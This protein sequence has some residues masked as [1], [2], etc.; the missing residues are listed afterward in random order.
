MASPIRIVRGSPRRRALLKNPLDRVIARHNDR[1][2]PLLNATLTIFQPRVVSP[3]GKADAKHEGQ[4]KQIANEEPKL[5]NHR[6]ISR[7]SGANDLHSVQTTNRLVW[8]ASRNREL[9]EASRAG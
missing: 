2:Q 7:M 4:P 1:F 9:H 3:P 6:D 8:L 5:A